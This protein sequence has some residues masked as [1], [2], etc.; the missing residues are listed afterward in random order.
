MI[1]RYIYIY[2]YAVPV[3]ANPPTSRGFRPQLHLHLQGAQGPAQRLGAGGHPHAQHEGSAQHPAVETAQGLLVGLLA[4]F[5]GRR[6]RDVLPLGGVGLG[7]VWTAKW[8]TA[9]EYDMEL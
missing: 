7:E 6:R 5:C 1:Y 8:K 2:T 3:P 4:G 9:L